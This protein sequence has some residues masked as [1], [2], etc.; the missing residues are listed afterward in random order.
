MVALK[1]FLLLSKWCLLSVKRPPQ[2]YAIGNT[3]IDRQLERI[4]RSHY[5]LS[6]NLTNMLWPLAKTSP[7]PSSNTPWIQTF[8]P[9]VFSTQLL[10]NTT[11]GIGK[12]LSYFTVNSAVAHPAVHCVNTGVPS[13]SSSNVA[14][15]PPCAKSLWG[16]YHKHCSRGLSDNLHT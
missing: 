10:H 7:F 5:N 4:A 12:G 1:I 6:L 16:L 9:S 15:R 14:M 2:W 13:V 3:D 8:L 11:A